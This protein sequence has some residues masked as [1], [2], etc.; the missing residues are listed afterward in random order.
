MS[1]MSLSDKALLFGGVALFVYFVFFRM[2]N[3][4]IGPAG[5]SLGLQKWFL[6]VGIVLIALGI[7]AKV[8]KSRF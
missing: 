6:I 5:D 7:V 3:D 1:S 2:I 4:A 8:I